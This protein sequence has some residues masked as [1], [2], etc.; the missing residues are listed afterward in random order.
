[1]ATKLE[2]FAEL[3]PLIQKEIQTE[4]AKLY[5]QYANKYGVASVPLHRHN[6]SDSPIIG[7]ASIFNFTAL[8]ATPGGV[9]NEDVLD[10]QVINNPAQNADGNKNPNPA[11]IYVMPIPIIYSSSGVG[12]GS[13]FEGGDAPQGT[14]VFFDGANATLS[15]LW[16]KTQN[17]WYRIATTSGPS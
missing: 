9:A 12:P 16:A 5:H 14:L 2:Q 17:G 10:A 11:N 13:A 4:F 6:G 15:G 8:P 1:M 3:Q 7:N